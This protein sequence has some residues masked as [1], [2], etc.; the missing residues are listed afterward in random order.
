MNRQVIE[1][2]QNFRYAG[3]LVNLKKKLISYEIRSK[4]AAGNID[5]YTVYGKYLGL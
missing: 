3:A 5:V 1:G 2:V 4:F